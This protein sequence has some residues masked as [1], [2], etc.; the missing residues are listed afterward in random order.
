MHGGIKSAD[1]SGGL[2]PVVE[3]QLGA[4]ALVYFQPADKARALGIYDQSIEIKYDRPKRCHVSRS[5]KCTRR[6]ANRRSLDP[7]QR[8]RLTSNNS[9]GLKKRFSSVSAFSGLSEPWTK[10]NMVSFP[11]SPRIVP[12]AA[13][14]ESVGPMRSRTR[15]TAFSPENAMITTGLDCMN[16]FNSG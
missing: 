9:S 14:R 4:K 15:V 6:A 3:I 16:D 13:L 1:I 2:T 7:S 12:F 5:F 11:K 8:S 10:L